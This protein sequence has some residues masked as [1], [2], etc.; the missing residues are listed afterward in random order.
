MKSLLENIKIV[1]S[2]AK[3]RIAGASSLE[4]L[5]TEK[6]YFLGRKD[7]L[8][9]ALFARFK[10]IPSEERLSVG[11]ILNR[12]KRLVLDL[13][14]NKKAILL[15]KRERELLAS[16]TIDPTLPGIGLDL[17]GE[18]PITIV[19]ERI[20]DFFLQN[21]FDIYDGKSIETLYANFTSLNFKPDHPA[22]NSTDTFYLN[23]SDLL[24]THTS[25]SQI[26]YLENH[27]PPIRMI[28][29]GRVYRNDF[30]A[31][32]TP[33]FH[34]I[35]G[36]CIEHDLSFGSLKWFL[37]EFLSYFFDQDE[38]TTR[39]RPSYFPFTEP[40]AE[41]DF[42]CFKCSSSGCR[43]CSQTGYIELLGCGMVH[44]KVLENMGLDPNQ[45]RGFAFGMGID[46]LTM[47][48]YG[49]DDLRLFFSNKLSF[50]RQFS[51]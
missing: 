45:W 21:G 32:H 31:T 7:G 15:E 27:K 10:E 25:A 3:D 18:H 41:V 9:G 12:L 49:I 40:S 1:E 4:E 50:L 22:I 43:L 29:L 19:S 16:E 26:R 23:Q 36:L 17:G 24:R 14:E 37:K 42:G 33:M 47:L 30:D 44:P 35:E 11:P 51:G 6:V 2:A 20:V 34:Q 5:E 39:F 48:R 28:S 13:L 46:R 8:I 38:I